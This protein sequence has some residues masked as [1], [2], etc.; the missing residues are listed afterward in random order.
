MTRLEL[1]C[2]V[3]E[4]QGVVKAAEAKRGAVH[5]QIKELQAQISDLWLEHGK[6][7][8]DSRNAQEKVHDLEYELNVAIAK[9]V[10]ATLVG[11]TREDLLR[12]VEQAV[13]GCNHDHVHSDL[14]FAEAILTLLEEG[15]KYRRGLHRQDLLTVVL[16][17]DGHERVLTEAQRSRVMVTIEAWC[18]VHPDTERYLPP[19]E[20]AEW[21]R[22]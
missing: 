14:P 3:L 20:V 21:P 1:E 16:K 13:F 6:F 5:A 7:L 11:C 15:A 22:K 2:A 17:V 19:Y 8:N 12:R 10:A 18:P 4:A 9:E